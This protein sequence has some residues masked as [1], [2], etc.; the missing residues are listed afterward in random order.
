MNAT[1]TVSKYMSTA[2]KTIGFDQTLEQASDEMR[3]LRVRHLPVLKGGKLIGV[4][5]DR[6]LNLVLTFANQETL[7]LPVEEALTPDPYFTTAEAPLAEVAAKMAEHK[8]G[9]ALVMEGE[10]VIGIFTAIDALKALSQILE[11]KKS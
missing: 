3:K 9:C 7:L 4:V 5:S 10:K 2:P 1:E 11:S 8:Y 6:D